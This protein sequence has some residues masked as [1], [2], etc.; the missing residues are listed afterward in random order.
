MTFIYKKRKRLFEK[1]WLY[2]RRVTSAAPYVIGDRGKDA[3]RCRGRRRTH[4]CKASRSVGATGLL[5]QSDFFF[6]ADIL[7]IRG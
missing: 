7:R 5:V 6:F 2:T 4:L 1:T 3:D